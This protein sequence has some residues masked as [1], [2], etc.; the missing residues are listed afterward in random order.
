MHF[1]IGNGLVDSDAIFILC[2]TIEHKYIMVHNESMLNCL[3]NTDMN[4]MNLCHDKCLFL[5]IF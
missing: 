4:A 5:C 1:C 3:A 2:V